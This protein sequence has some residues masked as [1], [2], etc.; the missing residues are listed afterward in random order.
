MSSKFRFLAFRDTEFDQPGAWTVRVTTAARARY[1]SKGDV[2]WAEVAVAL[3][4]PAARDAAGAAWDRWRCVCPAQLR[5]EAF[6]AIST[7]GGHGIRLPAAATGLIDGIV[8]AD[9]FEEPGGGWLRLRIHGA[10]TGLGCLD[11]PGLVRFAE[12]WIGGQS[13]AGPS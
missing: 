2:L 3:P 12:E 7:P 6:P 8:T 9:V 13:S 11:G 1:R 10:R 4:F 5:L